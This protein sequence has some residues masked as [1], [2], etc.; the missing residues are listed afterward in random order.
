MEPKLTPDGIRGLDAVTHSAAPAAVLLHSFP[1]NE[2][3][4]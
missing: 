1:L 3:R 2:K 4:S